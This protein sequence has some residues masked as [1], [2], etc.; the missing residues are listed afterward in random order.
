MPTATLYVGY[1][2][3][4]YDPMITYHPAQP[5]FT[6]NIGT[7]L[8]TNPKEISVYPD[9]CHGLSADGD[10]GPQFRVLHLDGTES[11]LHLASEMSFI[12]NKSLIKSSAKSLST[13]WS[14]SKSAYSSTAA[15]LFN[16]LASKGKPPSNPWV[17]KMIEATVC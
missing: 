17:F 11:V 12:D 9:R 6:I 1:V 5:Q 7:K 8:S 4:V 10:I 13:S 14:T 16:I 2:L 15:W 3:K